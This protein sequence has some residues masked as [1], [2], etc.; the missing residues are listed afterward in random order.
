M[1]QQFQFFI[2]LKSPKTFETDIYIALFTELLFTVE[3][4]ERTQV[5][6]NSSVYTV[7]EVTYTPWATTQVIR[8][9]HTIYNH[10]GGWT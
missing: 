6:R 8:K 1:T 3:D 10:M 7:T 5:P 9:G 2:F 4:L